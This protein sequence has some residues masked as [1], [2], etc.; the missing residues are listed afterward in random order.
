MI[1]KALV[2]KP[3]I[4]KEVVV[5]DD[6]TKD[7]VERVRWLEEWKRVE[8]EMTA[9]EIAEMEHQQI[10]IPIEEQIAQLKEQLFA[11]DYKAIKYAEG[12]ISEEEYAPVKAER[13]AIRQQIREL[14][15]TP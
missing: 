11:T 8:R 13:E 3:E 9:E 2:K 4:Y 1:Y 12:W 14:E 6:G 15:Q 10:D 5:N 7:T